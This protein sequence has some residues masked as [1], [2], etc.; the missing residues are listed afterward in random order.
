[1]LIHFYTNDRSV[2]EVCLVLS[3]YAL[4]DEGLTIRWRENIWFP[5]STH[6]HVKAMASVSGT[7]EF[8][9]TSECDISKF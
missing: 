5:S 6:T 3:F 2:S 7:P 1:M 8:F 9:E 4:G